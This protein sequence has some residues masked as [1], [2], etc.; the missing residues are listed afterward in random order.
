MIVF[1]AIRTITIPGFA[2]PFS[3]LSHLIGAAVFAVLG[4]A[5]VL[6]GLRA[7]HEDGWRPGRGHV[8]S[9]VVFAVS[10]VLLLT[11]S[12]VFHM[13]GPGGAARAAMQR[14]DH[15]AIF[16]L[17]AGTFTPTHAILFRG[18]WRW[19]MLLLVWTLAVAGV[20]LKTIYF[21]QVSQIVGL[22]A[23]IGMG[24]I[25]LASMILIAR[26]Y[27][28]RVVMSLVLGG[29]A[30]TAGGI[31]DGLNAP[32][33]A[34]GVFGSHELFHVFVLLGLS[35]HWWFVWETAGFRTPE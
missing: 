35:L 8:G 34:A 12:G 24:W 22:T 19:G 30:Y 10:A 15:A 23:Y 18:V 11:M 4:V 21:T 17:I 32:V 33:L 1:A 28:K 29:L 5:L 7:R 27:G 26:R 14:L 31:V 25:G 9:L 2:D 6:K 3:S 13:L 20:I 16:V